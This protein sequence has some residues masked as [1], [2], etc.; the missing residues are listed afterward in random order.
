[1]RWPISGRFPRSGGVIASGDAAAGDAAWN[2]VVSSGGASQGQ[3]TQSLQ[4]RGLG[5]PKLPP[6]VFSGLRCERLEACG[7]LREEGPEGGSE[8]ILSTSSRSYARSKRERRSGGWSSLDSDF[9]LPSGFSRSGEFA[10]L[11]GMA[12]R[13]DSSLS[14]DISRGTHGC[15]PEGAS[16][17]SERS[18]GVVSMTTDS[19]HRQPFARAPGRMSKLKRRKSTRQIFF[20]EDRYDT[21]VQ[22]TGNAKLLKRI[23]AFDARRSGG[24][25]AKAD[26]SEAG[27]KELQV[28]TTAASPTAEGER[29][30]AAGADG[31]APS[32]P[33]GTGHGSAKM[34]LPGGAESDGKEL[35]LSYDVVRASSQRSDAPASALRQAGGRWETA[36]NQVRGQFFVVELSEAA[37]VTGIS[38]ELPGNDSGPRACR[39]AYSKDSVDGPWKDAFKFEILAREDTAVSYTHSYLKCAESFR[40]LLDLAFPGGAEEAWKAVFDVDRS[41]GLS[42]QEFQLGCHRLRTTLSFLAPAKKAQAGRHL[43][44]FDDLQRLYETLDTSGSGKL[45]VEDFATAGSGVVPEALFWRLTVQSTWGAAS[46]LQIFGP[47]R[48]YQSATDFL[49]RRSPFS[50]TLRRGAEN[51]ISA[52]AVATVQIDPT[53]LFIRQLA[54]RLDLQITLVEDVYAYFTA[55]DGDKTGLIEKR[56]FETL[57]MQLHGVEDI[58]QIPHSRMRFF[59][60]QADRDGSGDITFEEFLLWFHTYFLSDLDDDGLDAMF[61]KP[62]RQL[63]N[64]FYSSFSRTVPRIRRRSSTSDEGRR[65]SA[66][67]EGRRGSAAAEGRHSSVK[68][69][70]LRA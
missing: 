12:S 5:A 6:A 49:R 66:A 27:G 57:M 39:L 69:G 68:G 1:M 53:T 35:E 18:G 24:T 7:L 43:A 45:D 64:N 25:A 51:K 10:D 63:V 38:F 37:C 3:A 58:S 14:G 15:I 61:I 2:D 34:A 22:R 70:N 16:P 62:G 50:R 26:R 30:A 29:E 9:H 17:L 56:E 41:G 42:Y 11:F 48:L 46:K 13:C 67:A 36:L 55:A 40:T 28:V 8:E 32:T 47:L 52:S 44:T 60:Q 19:S 21:S 65:S 4:R 33:G 54:S 23:R 31:G 59:W 20:L